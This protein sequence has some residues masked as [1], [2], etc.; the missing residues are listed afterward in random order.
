MKSS[1]SSL[2]N[3]S[4]SGHCSVTAD[5]LFDLHRLQTARE[6][7][8]A[9]KNRHVLGE[10]G[11]LAGEVAGHDVPGLQVQKRT[12]GEVAES[13]AG[14]ELHIGVL[15]FLAQSEHPALVLLNA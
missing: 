14:R 10:H 12:Q 4:F 1:S 6:A 5:T 2:G 3:Q 7:V 9:A 15:D 8:A 11:H 13:Q